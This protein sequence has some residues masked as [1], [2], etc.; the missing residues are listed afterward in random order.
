MPLHAS[1]G[2]SPRAKGVL[3]IEVCDRQS[4]EGRCTHAGNVAHLLWI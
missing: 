4:N 1:K 2:Q 3:H